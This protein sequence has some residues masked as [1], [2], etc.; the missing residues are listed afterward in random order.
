MLFQKR[1]LPPQDPYNTMKIF[2][3]IQQMNKVHFLILSFLLF[4]GPAF[5]QVEK[6][7]VRRFEQYQYYNTFEYAYLTTDKRLYFNGE[8]INLSAVV[9]NQYFSSTDLS[10]IIYVD[11]IHENNSYA[12]QYV[13]R[14]SEGI[15][16]GVINIPTDVPTGNYQLIAYTN[17]MRNHDLEF[18]GFRLPI[19]IQNVDEK[20]Q[21]MVERIV[22]DSEFNE[23]WKEPNSGIEAKVSREGTKLRLDIYNNSK[24]KSDLYII[25][26][27]LNSI[28]I[29]A[30]V[31]AKKGKNSIVLPLD[32]FKGSFQRMVLMN[33]D[34]TI[35]KIVNFYLKE[36]KDVRS[37]KSVRNLNTI[38]FTKNKF[39]NVSVSNDENSML[40]NNDNSLFKKLYRIYYNVPL[41]VAMSD[42]SFDQM[43]SDNFLEDISK[44][45]Y[46]RWQAILD[47]VKRNDDIIFSPEKNIKLRGIISRGD[48]QLDEHIIGF[49]FFRNGLELTYQLDST[50]VFDLDVVL[51]TG[52]DYFKAALFDE[53]FSQ[54]P[55]D[56]KLDLH[57][58]DL[59][60]YLNDV[61]LFPEAETE[62]IIPSDLNFKYILSTYSNLKNTELFFWDDLAFDQENVVSDYIGLESFEEFVKEAVINV[63]VVGGAESPGLTMFNYSTGGFD[64]PQLTVI[65]NVVLSDARPLFDVS[66]DDIESMYAAFTEEKLQSTGNF[67]TKGIFAI[68]TKSRDYQVSSEYVDN[69]TFRKFN[70]YALNKSMNSTSDL[71]SKPSNKS[72]ANSFSEINLSEE[73]VANKSV[74]I[75]VLQADGSYVVYQ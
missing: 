2:Q 4:T 39:Y 23:S 37:I 57:K 75:E 32:P 52:S 64:K 41:N 21:A 73:D 15:V 9:L 61:L 54:L 8:T 1:S 71:F 51:L 66:L 68:K 53:N 20:P 7:V 30:K 3:K 63:S 25:S 26:E 38:G 60:E 36:D 10:S 50:G 27:G 69:N 44:Y 72:I 18:H 65:D 67:F 31:K 6:E 40:T 55:D 70:G 22:Y 28:Q 45:S 11:L 46:L 43:I 17:F 14:L 42:V 33:E 56:F 59:S 29:T 47:E 58:K 19:Y 49:H 24:S 35:L 16:N 74:K 13:F 5:T 48:E 12:E 34:Y 62:D